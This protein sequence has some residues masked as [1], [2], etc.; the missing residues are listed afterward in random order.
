MI[1][2]V[3][4]YKEA[5]IHTILLGQVP[6][7]G[8]GAAALPSDG[9]SLVLSGNRWHAPGFVETGAREQQVSDAHAIAATGSMG[10]RHRLGM[11]YQKPIR[12][13]I[14]LFVPVLQRQ[15]PNQHGFVQQ[16]IRWR[17][18]TIAT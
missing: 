7:P 4:G 13:K 8:T 1:D 14:G 9:R 6:Y 18:I 2:A 15:A 17:D 10:V 3:G 11:R 16:H 12:W 5:G